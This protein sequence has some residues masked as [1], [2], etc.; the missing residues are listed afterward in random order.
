MLATNYRFVEE[1]KGERKREDRQKDVG[2]GE[3]ETKTDRAIER[4][5]Y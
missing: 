4:E 1:R 2:Y 3:T 5:K